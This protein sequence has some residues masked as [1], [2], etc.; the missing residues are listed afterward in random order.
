MEEHGDLTTALAETGVNAQDNIPFMIVLG[1]IKLYG[2]CPPWSPYDDTFL[3]DDRDS[4][5]DRV[6]RSS[7]I[8]AMLPGSSPVQTRLSLCQ[9]VSRT[10]S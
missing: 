1:Y 5:L 6:F 8:E 7:T 10:S 2:F 9:R 3:G 4:Y